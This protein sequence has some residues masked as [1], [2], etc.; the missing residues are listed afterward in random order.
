MKD[1]DERRLTLFLFPPAKSEAT[2]GESSR[3]STKTQKRMSAPTTAAPITTAYDAYLPAFQ[4]ATQK[5]SSKSA[6]A[7]QQLLD[8]DL[9]TFM[10]T[11]LPQESA[12]H[13]ALKADIIDAVKVACHAWV[14]HVALNRCRMLPADA[15]DNTWGR[16]EVSGSYRL[17]LRDPGADIDAVFIGPSF[18]RMDDLFTNFVPVMQREFS[19]VVRSGTKNP[20]ILAIT[21]VISVEDATVPVLSFCVSGV[22]VDLMFART[23]PNSAAAVRASLPAFVDQPSV[24]LPIDCFDECAGRALNG[25]RCTAMIAQ[26]VGA[27]NMATYLVVLRCVRRWAK[28]RGI[29]SNKMGY[30]GGVNLAIMVAL[31]CQL[32]PRC[33]SSQLLA[34]FFNRFRGW[35]AQCPVMLNHVLES[36]AVGRSDATWSAN[37]HDLFPVITPTYPAMNSSASVN[38]HS[39]HIIRHEMERA[40]SIVSKIVVAGNDGTAAA[41]KTAKTAKTAKTT[42]AA[43][44]AVAWSDLFQPSD[45]YTRFPCYLECRIVCGT[46]VAANRAWTGFVESQI[47]ALVLAPFLGDLASEISGPIYLFPVSRTVG[48]DVHYCIGFAPLGSIAALSTKIQAKVVGVFRT[49]LKEKYRGCH[50]ADLDFHA[51]VVLREQLKMP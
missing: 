4:L 2:T 19:S 41:T 26:L 21:D 23:L 39:L 12:E 11:V 50:C 17:G 25:P 31:L 18:C 47:R 3:C 45:F 14:R 22:S 36:A 48:R 38:L 16:L 35:E 15:E 51:S 5:S 8:R 10:E 27:E 9:A 29:Y 49:T 44:T 43:P 37:T 30:F 40:H 6:S 33:A 13:S 1:D 24:L 34:R 28:V 46:N 7:Q 20:N 42:T 32:Y